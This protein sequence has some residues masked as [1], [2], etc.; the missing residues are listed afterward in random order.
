LNLDECDDE[1]WDVD[2]GD[3]QFMKISMTHNQV[4]RVLAVVEG[5]YTEHL[6]SAVHNCEVG[7][8]M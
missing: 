3:V 6:I 1:S 7:I 2:I 8:D 5:A 4:E